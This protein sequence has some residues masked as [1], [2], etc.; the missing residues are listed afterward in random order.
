MKMWNSGSSQTVLAR[1]GGSPRA[2]RL[3]LEIQNIVSSLL[4]QRLLFRLLRG[5]GREAGAKLRT[6]SFGGLEE[7]LVGTFGL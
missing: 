6:R 1:P 2:F 5:R 3:V 4:T 7:R